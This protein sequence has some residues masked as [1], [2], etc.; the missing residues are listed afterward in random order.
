MAPDNLG[1]ESIIC[2]NKHQQILSILSYAK[3][4]AISFRTL[5]IFSTGGY[6]TRIKKIIRCLSILSIFEN[7]VIS[8]QG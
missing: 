8:K 1:N 7:F 4:S 3:V 5:L 6:I 2:S